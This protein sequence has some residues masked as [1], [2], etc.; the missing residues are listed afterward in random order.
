MR[1]GTFLVTV[2]VAAVTTLYSTDPAL[3]TLVTT[4]SAGVAVSMVL[5]LVTERIL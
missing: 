5:F 4:F 3:E 2:L 1:V